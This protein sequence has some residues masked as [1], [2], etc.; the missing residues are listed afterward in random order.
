ML[1][2]RYD[3]RANLPGNELVEVGSGAHV[4]RVPYEAPMW[5]PT[6]IHDL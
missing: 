4:F 6:G 5:P 2:A 1:S 3:G